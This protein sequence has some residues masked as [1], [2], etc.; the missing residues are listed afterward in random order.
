MVERRRFTKVVRRRLS[1]PIEEPEVEAS[2]ERFSTGM[3]SW[4]KL[5]SDRLAYYKYGIVVVGRPLKG[6]AF[7][8][9]NLSADYMYLF[10]SIN[11]DQSDYL[12][13]RRA[14]KMSELYKIA[15]ESYANEPDYKPYK[16]AHP[17]ARSTPKQLETSG[18]LFEV[19][20]AGLPT[21]A[22]N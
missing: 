3:I 6:P 9:R 22:P 16:P 1:K 2:G 12:D 5:R 8:I 19:Q 7:V 13:C 11:E 21:S 17:V 18:R 10:R 4:I 20:L 15:E 14:H